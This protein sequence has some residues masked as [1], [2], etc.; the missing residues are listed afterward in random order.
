[1][2]SYQIAVRRKTSNL[3]RSSVRL[4]FCQ[5]K[6]STETCYVDPTH[7]TEISPPR[8]TGFLQCREELWTTKHFQWRFTVSLCIA[9]RA[10]RVGFGTLWPCPV[11]SRVRVTAR[12]ILG[13]SSRQIGCWLN[14]VALIS[15]ARDS[16]CRGSL[17][18]STDNSS[19]RAIHPHHV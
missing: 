10:S 16:L 14:I 5:T 11:Q 3:S 4:S 12:G 18:G 1:M 19:L 2:T 15:F 13:S 7:V 8:R 17:C 9:C 6:W